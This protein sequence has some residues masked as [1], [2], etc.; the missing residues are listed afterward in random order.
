[1]L[2]KLFENYQSPIEQEHI[3][4]QFVKTRYVDREP[5]KIIQL[6]QPKLDGV[7]DIIFTEFMDQRDK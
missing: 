2:S 1:M 4:K 6:I 7:E 3:L 5:P